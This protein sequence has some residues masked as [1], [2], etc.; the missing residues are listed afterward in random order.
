[1]MPLDSGIDQELPSFPPSLGLNPVPSEAP[2]HSLSHN[3]KCGRGVALTISH[4]KLQFLVLS[5][6]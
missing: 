2:C 3:S 5:I 6:F 1:M 4:G